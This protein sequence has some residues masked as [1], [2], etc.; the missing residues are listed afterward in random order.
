MKNVNQ[1]YTLPNKTRLVFLKFPYQ[2]TDNFHPRE[3]PTFLFIP[4]ILNVLVSFYSSIFYYLYAT[5]NPLPKV[6]KRFSDLTS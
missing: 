4:L 1:D 2:Y 3:I 6:G 5:L